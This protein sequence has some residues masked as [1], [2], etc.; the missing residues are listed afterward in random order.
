MIP[1]KPTQNNLIT[2]SPCVRNCCLNERD[3][4]IGCGR[5]I[6]EITGWMD[7]TD[8]QKNSV[9]KA[10]EQRLIELKKP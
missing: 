3:L 8:E 4:C 5:F 9:I 2:A 10:A 1:P 6:A 7:F